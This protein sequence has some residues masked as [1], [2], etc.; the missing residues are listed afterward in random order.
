[1]STDLRLKL[2]IDTREANRAL[3]AVHDLATKEAQD[4][5]KQSLAAETAE[6]VTAAIEKLD[7]I[8]DEARKGIEETKKTLK[9]LSDQYDAEFEKIAEKVR[10]E[11]EKGKSALKEKYGT[12]NVDE[13]IRNTQ[14]QSES[15]RKLGEEIDKVQQKLKD[16]N[17]LE[18]REEYR[19]YK[20]IGDLY[21]IPGGTR[22]AHLYGTDSEMEARQIAESTSPVLNAIRQ[23]IQETEAELDNLSDKYGEEMEKTAVRV[24]EEM[25]KVQEAFKEKY[26]TS[27]VEEAISNTQVQ[28]LDGLVQK[29]DEATAAQ[30]NY[31]AAV[32]DSDKLRGVLTGKERAMLP[33]SGK[34]YGNTFARSLEQALRRVPSIISG[35]FRR[36]LNLAKRAATSLFSFLTRGMRSS[37]SGAGSAIDMITGRIGK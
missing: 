19:I 36:G 4:I 30:K 31:N 6:Q 27:D 24:R 37:L 34:E 28:E 9:G 14:N 5:Q 35:A 7:R 22:A 23:A 8:T 33:Y 2:K 16:L 3:E 18:G 25:G 10:A 17:N 20:E 13:A 26:G 32:A 15:I 21:S 29:I 1:M 11:F 12:D